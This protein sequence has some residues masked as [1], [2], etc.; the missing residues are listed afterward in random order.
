MVKGIEKEPHFSE[1]KAQSPG[2]GTE[3]KT[4]WVGKPGGLC[5]SS[6]RQELQDK[7]GRLERWKLEMR[8]LLR[9]RNHS[10]TKGRRISRV[11]E[12]RVR[13]GPSLLG[14]PGGKGSARAR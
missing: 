5:P 3:A 8:K 10:W 11:R 13:D 12:G 6:T 2:G 14:V 1:Q 7:M 9:R 4:L